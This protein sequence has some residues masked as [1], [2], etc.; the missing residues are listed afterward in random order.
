LLNVNRKLFLIM[1]IIFTFIFA[2]TKQN[3]AKLNSHFSAKKFPKI[4]NAWRG[5]DLEIKK[6]SGVF[7]VMSKEDLILRVYKNSNWKNEIKMAVVLA[8]DK[9]KIHDPK[10]CY[11]LQ[12]FEFLDTKKIKLPDG[13][14]ANY[15]KTKKAGKEYSF[16]YWYTDLDADYSD[17]SEF[18]KEIIFKK[19]T[20]KRIKTYGIVILYTPTENTENLKKFAPEVNDILIN[21]IGNVK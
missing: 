11:K 21:Q 14:N 18:W 4:I 20:G 13:L 3:T 19:L 8:D 12:G 7:E 15:I 6:E 16:I 10:I 5:E 1:I 9:K 17:R 2:N